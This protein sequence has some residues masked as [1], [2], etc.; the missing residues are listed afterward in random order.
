MLIFLK[1]IRNIIYLHIIVLSSS[2]IYF[3]YNVKIVQ[4]YIHAYYKFIYHAF[5]F[6][7]LL[8]DISET[9]NYVWMTI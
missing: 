7:I 6:L 8:N 3:N 2:I 5:F 9:L 4:V 1:K